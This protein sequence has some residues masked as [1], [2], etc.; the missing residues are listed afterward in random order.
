MLEVFTKLMV[1][2]DILLSLEAFISY[3]NED[4]TRIVPPQL[5]KKTFCAPKIQKLSPKETYV[6]LP[7]MAERIVL[8]YWT[9]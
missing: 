4:M 7:F 5:S 2:S 8:G 3:K 6:L 1:V 9:A